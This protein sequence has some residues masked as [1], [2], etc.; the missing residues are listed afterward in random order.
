MFLMH[1]LYLGRS[2]VML[3]F[4][5]LYK[6]YFSFYIYYKYNWLM[7]LLVPPARSLQQSKN[8][9]AILRLTY[10]FYYI[11]VLISHT[12]KAVAP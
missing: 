6:L 5:R 8:L 2:F 12:A 1:M 11:H 9:F 3:L 4:P 7:H 10:N